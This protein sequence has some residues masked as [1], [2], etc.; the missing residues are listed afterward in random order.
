MFGLLTIHFLLPGCA[1]LKEKRGRIQPLIHRLKREFNISVAEMDL[2]D[3]WQETV[4]TCGMVGNDQVH[5]E[6]SLQ[7]IAR[8]VGSNWLDLQVMDEKIELV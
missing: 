3:K 4:I 8:W 6:Q 1:S 5:L 7:A 2:Q